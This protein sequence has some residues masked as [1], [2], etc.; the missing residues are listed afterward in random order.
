MDDLRQVLLQPAGPYHWDCG[1]NY[2][3]GGLAA[4]TCAQ[5]RL[6]TRPAHVRI[7]AYCEDCAAMH[8][9]Q[10]IFHAYRW[11]DMTYVS[12]TTRAAV[13]AITHPHLIHR[14]LP[15]PYD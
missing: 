15:M 3:R 7:D 2:V 12:Q 4:G 9:G 8:A 11:V 6:I 14:L 1:V 5:D 10:E 13:L